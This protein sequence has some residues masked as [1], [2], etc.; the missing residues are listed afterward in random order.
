MIP[1][2]FHTFKSFIDVSFSG[3][4][5]F[6]Q[7]DWMVGWWDGLQTVEP[8]N[9]EYTL[10]RTRKHSPPNRIE[11]GKIIIDSN[12]LAAGKEGYVIRWSFPRGFGLSQQVASLSQQVAHDIWEIYKDHSLPPVGVVTPKWWWV[13]VRESGP[14]NGRKSQVKDLY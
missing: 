6:P 9:T 11:V 2:C 12:M 13:L 10:R 4:Y 3:V 8:T 1:F 7:V 5:Q 14:Q